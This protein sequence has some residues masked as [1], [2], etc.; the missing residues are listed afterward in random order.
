MVIPQEKRG[1]STDIRD[2]SWIWKNP[3]WLSFP[4]MSD[5]FLSQAR[6]LDEVE[7]QLEDLCSYQ[8]FESEQLCVF[9]GNILSS[10]NLEGIRLSRKSVRSSLADALGLGA[11]EWKRRSRKSREA[12]RLRRRWNCCQTRRP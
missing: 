7:K 3:D 2:R 11:A 6:N 5:D 12:G 1:L 10:W 8:G 9:A 4:D